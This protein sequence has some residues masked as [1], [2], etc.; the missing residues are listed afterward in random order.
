LFI[1]FASSFGWLHDNSW[2]GRPG[3][4]VHQPAAQEDVRI[5]PEKCSL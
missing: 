4:S 3:G 1:A 2:L 5:N